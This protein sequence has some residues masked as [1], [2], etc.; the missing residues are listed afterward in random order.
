MSDE[1]PIQTRV[2]CRKV[3][4]HPGDVLLSVSLG[5]SIISFDVRQK[6]QWM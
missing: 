1:S 6:W 2:Q 4:T 5:E 3:E